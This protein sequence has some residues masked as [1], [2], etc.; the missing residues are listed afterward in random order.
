MPGLDSFPYQEREKGET[1]QNERT[2]VQYQHTMSIYRCPGYCK[3]LWLLL[4]MV[5]VEEGIL[6]GQMVSVIEIHMAQEQ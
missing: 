3:S 1:K 2:M 6:G 5:N 4:Q